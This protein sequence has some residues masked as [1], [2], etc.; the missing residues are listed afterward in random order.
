MNAPN[1]CEGGHD[2]PGVAFSADDVWLCKECL[3]ACTEIPVGGVLLKGASNALR[4]AL[5]DAISA[6]ATGNWGK[7]ADALIEAIAELGGLR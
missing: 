7:L 6:K 4:K 5:N 2:V 1:Q 3:D